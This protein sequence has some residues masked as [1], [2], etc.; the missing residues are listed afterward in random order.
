MEDPR[1]PECIRQL[2]AR[3]TRQPAGAS[4]LIN[5]HTCVS[6]MLK[7]P[8]RRMH[9][10]NVWVGL[11]VRGRL[12]PLGGPRPV[13]TQQIKQKK[14]GT[15][16]PSSAYLSIYTLHPIELTMARWQPARLI[17]ATPTHAGELRE[18]HMVRPVGPAH[19]PPASTHLPA[20]AAGQ[21][22]CCPLYR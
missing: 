1:P 2:G 10:I 11:G 9:E 8:R 22:L 4:Y 20:V 3:P 16:P 6:A 5:N 12:T 17:W 18:A 7:Q 21:Q 19:R 13:S 15:R 14:R